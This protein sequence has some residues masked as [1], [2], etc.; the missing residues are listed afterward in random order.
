MDVEECYGGS[1]EQERIKGVGVI[2]GLPALKLTAIVGKHQ[3]DTLVV[4]H[5]SY[6]AKSIVEKHGSPIRLQGF[7]STKPT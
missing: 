2:N 3:V 5:S 7:H 1:T 4:H 6:P